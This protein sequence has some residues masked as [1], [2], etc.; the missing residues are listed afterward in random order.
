MANGEIIIQIMLITI[1]MVALSEVLNKILGI[2]MDAARELRE[3]SQ[4]LQ[5]RMQMARLMRNPEE[6]LALQKESVELYKQ[7]MYNILIL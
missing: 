2:N 6:M 4:N 5:E 1:G 7:L 3:K